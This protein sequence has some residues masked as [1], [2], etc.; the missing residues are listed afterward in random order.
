MR[1]FFTARDPVVPI[2]YPRLLV[3]TAVAGGANREALLESA[4]ISLTTLEDPEGLI[5]YA[6]LSSLESAAERLT[7]DPGVALRWGRAIRFS[8][9]GLVG[10]AAMSSDNL[11][12][13]FRIAKQYYLQLIPGWELELEVA[14][15]RA[16]LSIEETLDRGDLLRFAT[17][18]VVSG[19]YSVV[20]QA[21][22]RPPR[23]RLYRF[24]YARPAHYHY[25]REYLGDAEFV[26][27][28]TVTEGEFDPAILGERMATSAPA[29][30]RLLEQYSAN[31]AARGLQVEGLAAQVRKVLMD[32][33]SRRV[34]LAEVARALQ[35]SPRSLR[36]GLGEMGTSYQEISG[37]V[38]RQR[39]EQLV[40]GAGAKI[41]LVAQELGFTDAR[42][43]RRAFKRW[44][45]QSPNQF[46]RK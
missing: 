33:G 23:V 6:Q 40:R 44:T 2:H 10:I 46:R 4:G 11:F 26:F 45:G 13:A 36:R 34:S 12:E 35:T 39:A 5:S 28:Q 14:G 22:G 1:K 25:Y 16:I 37:E 27:D 19:F 20:S 32:A 15:D 29:T 38:L 9:S 31:V 3:E 30:S 18:A 43:F 42:S 41:D 24:K 8:H 7:D 17:E 21:L